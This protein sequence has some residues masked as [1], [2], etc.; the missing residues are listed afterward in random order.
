METDFFPPYLQARGSSSGA[1]GS[2]PPESTRDLA[3]DLQLLDESMP[4]TL[5]PPATFSD[6]PPQQQQQ[7]GQKQLQQLRVQQ[8]QQQQQQQQ[9]GANASNGGDLENSVNKF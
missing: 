4:V 8:Q 6:H 2:L 3:S 5:L 1:S 7:Q 9:R